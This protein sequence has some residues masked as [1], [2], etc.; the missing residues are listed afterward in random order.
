ME[1]IFDDVLA[2]HYGFVYLSPADDE[3]PD[4][5]D[6]RRG[7]VNGLLGAGTG[8]A[9]SLTTGTHT[10]EVPFRIEWHDVEPSLDDSWTDVVEASVE[11][12]DR[13]MRLSAFDDAHEVR[14]PTTGPHRV[15]LCASGFEAASREEDLD[16]D[17]VPD[18]YWVQLWPAP[19]T[20]D[21][22]VRV[23]SRAAQYW[24]DEAQTLTSLSDEEW[25][26]RQVASNSQPDGGYEPWSPTIGQG[27]SDEQLVADIPLSLRVEL[28]EPLARRACEAAGVAELE[29][30]RSALAALRQWEPLPAT[31]TNLDEVLASVQ[32]DLMTSGGPTAR[33]TTAAPDAVRQAVH[34]VFAAAGPDSV[35]NLVPLLE[36]AKAATGTSG[37][38]LIRQVCTER[39]YG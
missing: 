10:G 7:Q 13:D 2:V 33:R 14:L 18:Q 16:D 4:L 1:R 23:S 34:A 5:D 30:I 21:R 36:L 15:R 6:S 39:G 25:A 3:D 12:T 38:D 20:A 28:R 22:I 31:V 26:A 19:P 35:M 37:E 9:L 27:R 29:P 17:R 8:T 11:I 24:H 32:S